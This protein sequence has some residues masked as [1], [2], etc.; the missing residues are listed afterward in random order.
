M[1][2]LEKVSDTRGLMVRFGGC[3]GECLR[4]GGWLQ[5]KRREWK[6]Y[7]R[8]NSILLHITR[9][10]LAFF[11]SFS[12][13]SSVQGPVWPL[14]SVLATCL[15]FVSHLFSLCKPC[16]FL[17]VCLWERMLFNHDSSLW[18]SSTPFVSH[19]SSVTSFWIAWEKGCRSVWIFHW[20]FDSFCRPLD[21][22]RYFAFSVV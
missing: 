16:V 17:L 12:G 19:D 8:W 10:E 13:F 4:S 18:L 15:Q 20:L 2:D 11:T 21:S 7:V 22:K 6:R 3:C 5:E 14:V 9:W 1:K